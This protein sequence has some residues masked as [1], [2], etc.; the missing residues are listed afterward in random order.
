MFNKQCSLPSYTI[1]ELSLQFIYFRLKTIILYNNIN[2]ITALKLCWS[3]ARYYYIPYLL[4]TKS[5]YLWQLSYYEKKNQSLPSLLLHWTLDVSNVT[6]NNNYYNEGLSLNQKK[7]ILAH[8]SS[9]MVRSIVSQSPIASNVKSITSNVRESLLTLEQPSSILFPYF[10]VSYFPFLIPAFNT[11]PS[12]ILKI[13]LIMWSC[14]FHLVVVADFKRFSDSN[15]SVAWVDF[16]TCE[17]I[18]EH[19]LTTL[20]M[21]PACLK[22]SFIT[23]W[24]ICAK[25]GRCS[26]T[27]QSSS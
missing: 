17:T 14:E 2:I 3:H 20:V 10:S 18:V 26:L 21:F 24:S 15:N 27:W 19:L 13:D 9:Q 25:Q 23:N 4:L 12:D 1:D 11:T 5:D 16:L 6:S 22:P 7:P 8:L